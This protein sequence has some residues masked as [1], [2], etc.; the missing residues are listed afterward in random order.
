MRTG[1]CFGWLLSVLLV[2]HP[3]N[4]DIVV[5][6]LDST[7]TA[8]GKGFVDV[9]IRSTSSDLISVVGYEF[10]ITGFNASGTLRFSPSEQQ[11]NA[12]SLTASTAPANYIFLNSTDTNNYGNIRQDPNL[13]TIVG[14]DLKTGAGNIA[15]TSDRLL[16]RLYL[17]HL[18]PTPESAKGTYQIT[19]VQGPN[20]VFA[21]TTSTRPIDASSFSTLG[22]GAVT[23]IAVPEPNTLLL[24]AA[25]LVAAAFLQ[26][27]RLTRT[28][29]NV[30]QVSEERA[31]AKTRKFLPGLPVSGIRIPQ[32][33]HQILD[34]YCLH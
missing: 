22:S 8:N 4:G 3:V 5:D 19:L 18:T 6:V 29:L 15:L 31:S 33:P 28:R 17:E 25:A 16:T 34:G 2:A 27:G 11:Q 12:Q 1:L 23:I 9:L 26:R 13:T 10:S 30:L 21:S 7:I 20:T 32:N 24:F 14:G